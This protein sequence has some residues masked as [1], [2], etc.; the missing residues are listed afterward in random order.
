M[1]EIARQTV[2]QPHR[3]SSIG[4]LG[5]FQN[6]KSVSRLYQA[7]PVNDFLLVISPSPSVGSRSLPK[8]KHRLAIARVYPIVAHIILSGAA[9]DGVPRAIA[10]REFALAV[11]SVDIVADL[12][13]FGLPINRVKP[14]RSEER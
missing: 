5:N 10:D 1:G 2:D 8:M 12:V 11:L 13:I 7:V 4:C 14:T 9:L 3:G 6:S